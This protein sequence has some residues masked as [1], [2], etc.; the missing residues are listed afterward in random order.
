MKTCGKCGEDKSLDEFAWK[1]QA[2]G[3]R[4]WRCKPC[5]KIYRTEHYQA[6]K[7]NIYRQIKTRQRELKN[8]IWDYKKT[9]PCMDCGET[10]PIVLEF[11]HLSDKEFN[12]GDA[13]NFGYSWERIL[14]EIRKCNVVCR[15]CH[16]RRTWQRARWSRDD[17]PASLV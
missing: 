8:K 4:Q 11:D 2:K 9:H 3:T 1:E 13:G 7:E 12:V 15:N 16:V 10:D 14:N 5:Q 17:L 6:N